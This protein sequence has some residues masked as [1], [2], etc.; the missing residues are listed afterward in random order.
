MEAKSPEKQEAQVPGESAIFARKLEL[1]ELELKK[2]DLEAAAKA[3]SAK[4]WWASTLE[5]L[6]LPAAVIAI[7]LQLTQASGNV[8]TGAKTQAETAKIRVE[9][10][11][12]RVELEKMLD[13]LAE[14]KG[15]GVTAYREEVERAI[16]KLQDAIESLRRLETLA[17]SQL[18]ERSVA[19]FVLL[20]ILFHAVGLVFDVIQQGWGTLFASLFLFVFARRPKD[21]STSDHERHQK[22]LKYAQISAALLSPV[23]NVLRWS[24]QLS[25]FFALMVPLFNEVALGLGSNTQ[26]DTLVQ[27]AKHLE[28]SRAL[29]MMKEV[30]FGTSR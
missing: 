3:P 20:W 4:P 6:A 21:D 28:I 1:L 13:D 10:M 9:E 12:T 29:A 14:T 26:F 7:V 11:K 22:R 23:P 16:P 27:Q 15:K 19:K 30:L 8:Q 25:I 17:S 24:I 18:L 5:F 2:R